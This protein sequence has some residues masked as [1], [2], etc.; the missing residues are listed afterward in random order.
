VGDGLPDKC[1]GFRH[2]TVILCCHLRQVNEMVWLARQKMYGHLRLKT[3]P[4]PD[5]TSV[6]SLDTGPEMVGLG[7]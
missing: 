2:S 5:Q 4:T 7:Q 1:V 3:D 6:L